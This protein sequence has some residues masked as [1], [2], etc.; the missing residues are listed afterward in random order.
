MRQIQLK[1][2]QPTRN[3]GTSPSEIEIIIR[4]FEDSLIE[5]DDFAETLT[6]FNRR[7]DEFGYGGKVCH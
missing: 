4:N 5:K 1:L 2:N 7:P 6:L 3:I